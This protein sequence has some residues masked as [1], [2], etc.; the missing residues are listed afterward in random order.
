MGGEDDGAGELFERVDDLQEAGPE[1]RALLGSEAGEDVDVD[2]A[3]DG[4][5]GGLDQDGARRLVREA[6]DGRAEVVHHRLVE[7]VQRRTVEG[8]D[9]EATGLGFDPDD[10]LAIAHATTLPALGSGHPVD[11]EEVRA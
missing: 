5:A 6:E 1:L 7:E 3:G 9:G 10:G 8:E 11:L 4:A 2:P